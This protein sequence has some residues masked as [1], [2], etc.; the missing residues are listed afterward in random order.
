MKKIIAC[1]LF[2]IQSTLPLSYQPFFASPRSF[3]GEPRL[4]ESWLTTVDVSIKGGHGEDGHNSYKQTVNPLNIYGCENFRV[5]AQGIPDN[6]LDCNPNG[7]INTLWEQT[8]RQSNF[9]LVAVKGKFNLLEFTPSLTQNLKYGFFLSLEIPFGKYSIKDVTYYDQTTKASA[10]SEQ[11]YYEWQSFINNIEK[12]LQ[13]YGLW[14][15]NSKVSGLEDIQ[16][17]GG[18][19]HSFED[20]K[21]LDFFDIMLSAGINLP[22]GKSSPSTAPF[23]LS[24]G[25]NK[26]VGFPIIAGFSVGFFDWI[27]LGVSGAGLVFKD[28]TRNVAMKTASEQSGWIRMG[29]GDALVHQ[30]SYVTLSPFVKADHLIA[31]FSLILGYSCDHQYRTCYTPCDTA[32]YNKSIVNSDIKLAPWNM[33]TFHFMLD[34][35]FAS[36]KHSWAPRIAFAIDKS[37]SGKRSFDSSTFGAALTCDI[38][39]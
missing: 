25:Y 12:N 4:T 13:P 2:M 3:L 1:S 20:F 30:G 32:T 24:L 28:K 15:G 16:I 5:L 7:Y 19:S 37:M 22:T 11:E 14:V 21:I 38:G 26:Q 36:F 6:I 8:P 18:W 35:D 23:C 33:N 29:Q 10:P 17:F 9:G 39:W 27:T 34:F 31:G